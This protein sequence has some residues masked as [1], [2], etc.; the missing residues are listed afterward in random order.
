MATWMSKM[1]EQSQASLNKE[2]TTT[3]IKHTQT[4]KKNAKNKITMRV[5]Q[6]QCK[7]LKI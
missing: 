3:L 7:K 2:K 6:W 1:M 5:L 4:K